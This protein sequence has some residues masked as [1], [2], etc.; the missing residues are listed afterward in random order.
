MGK[1]GISDGILNVKINGPESGNFFFPTLVF[2][3]IGYV[4][5]I[6]GYASEGSGEVSRCVVLR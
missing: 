3:E 2:L 4:K 6:I 5:V 1:L